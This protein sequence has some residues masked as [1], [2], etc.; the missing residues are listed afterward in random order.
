MMEVVRCALMKAIATR[1]QHR[2]SFIIPMTGLHMCPWLSCEAEAVGADPVHE[3]K[4]QL[5]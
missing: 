5:L 2:G 4:G 3:S 1:C